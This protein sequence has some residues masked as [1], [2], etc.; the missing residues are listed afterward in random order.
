MKHRIM[1]KENNS[2]TQIM[3]DDSFN[4]DTCGIYQIVLTLLLVLPLVC[5]K[6]IGVDILGG[7]EL[8]WLLGFF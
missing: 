4:L 8:P 1:V 5:N 7:W 6:K 3:L 2:L